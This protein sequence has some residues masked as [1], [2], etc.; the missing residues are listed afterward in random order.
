MG[1]IFGFGAGAHGGQYHMLG[2][3]FGQQARQPD[4]LKG[5]SI[6]AHAGG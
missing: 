1:L 6:D 5:L 3:G 2:L 4:A